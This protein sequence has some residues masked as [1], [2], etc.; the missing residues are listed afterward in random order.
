MRKGEELKAPR[1]TSA[2]ASCDDHVT[3]R[4]IIPNSNKDNKNNSSKGNIKDLNININFSNKPTT[5]DIYFIYTY[6]TLF[7]KLCPKKTKLIAL[8]LVNK[9]FI[10]LV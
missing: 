8:T 3:T 6:Y 2:A 10:Y 9:A 5:I 7:S 4:D 1:H